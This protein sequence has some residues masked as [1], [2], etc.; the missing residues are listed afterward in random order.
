MVF[1]QGTVFQAPGILR[2]TE[3]VTGG[4]TLAAGDNGILLNVTSGSGTIV[5]D[6]ATL[7]AGYKFAVYN[8]GSGSPVFDPTSTQTIRLPTGTVS[9]LAIV[10][11]QGITFVSDGSNWLAILGIGFG[12]APTATVTVYDNAFSILDNVDPTK[13]AMFQCSSISAGTTCTFTL[14]DASVILAGSASALTSGRIPVAVAGGLLSDSANSPTLSGANLTIQGTLTMSPTSGTAITLLH[15]AG[16]SS[17]IVSA[18][19][20]IIRHQRYGYSTGYTAVQIGDSSRGIGFGIDPNTVAGG[21]FN[22]N[23]KDFFFA[24]DVTFITP[25]AGG[26]DWECAVRI[27]GG[28]GTANNPVVDI[29]SSGLTLPANAGG[30]LTVNT[31]TASTSTT[32]GS[33]INAGGFGNAGA[34][35]FGGAVTCSSTATFSGNTTWADGINIVVNTTTGT[36]IGTATTQKIGLW[37]A[38]P[39]VQPSSTGETTGWTTGG[40]SAA[41]STDTYTGNSGTKA[42]T[43]NDIVKHLK[44]TGILATS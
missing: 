35:Y 40:G 19:G 20:N 12:P 32:T 37:N 33:L 14:P 1:L 38:T 23:N 7:G 21:Q 5:A 3:A 39:I 26:T 16:A 36:K 9:T 15:N 10:Q 43:V 6:A 27:R 2:E 13:I 8:E 22:G 18:Y 34:A 24:R 4:R 17:Q 25:N 11:G 44:A 30:I 31:T 29:T 42:Y 41:T 28:S